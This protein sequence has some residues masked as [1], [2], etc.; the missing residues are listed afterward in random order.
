MKRVALLVPED[1][2]I[3]PLENARHGLRAANAYLEQSGGAPCFALQLVAATPCVQLD[4]GRVQLQV[5]ATLDTVGKVDLCVVPPPLREDGSVLMSPGNQRLI[6]WVAAHYQAGG[7]VASLCMGAAMLAAAGVLDG[8]RAV[9]HWAVQQAYAQRFPQVD[10]A[11]DGIVHYESGIYTSGGAF[12]AAHLILHLIEQ[13]AGR[14]AAIWCA[15][16]FQLDWS[17]RSQQP[18]AIFTGHKAHADDVVRAVQE[19]LEA[20]YAERLS[21]PALADRFILGR[22]TLERRFR[23]AT[24]HSIVE[25]LQRIRVEAA[26]RA[27]EN[28]RKSVSE[29]MYDVGYNDTKAFRDTFARYSGMTPLSY[30]ERYLL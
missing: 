2:N 22:R 7:E 16:Y 27:L 15:K 10:W 13:H 6:E 12:S 5:D 25:Y 26:K 14:E 1:A 28:S 17:R 18:F 21:I 24:G 29:V 20:H 23:Q 4:G 8:R 30:R 11:S 19:Y 3:A 9:V